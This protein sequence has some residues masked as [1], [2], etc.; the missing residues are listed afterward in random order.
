MYELNQR[1]NFEEILTLMINLKYLL[2]FEIKNKIKENESAF[3]LK[4]SPPNSNLQDFILKVLRDNLNFFSGIFFSKD[5][6]ISDIQIDSVNDEKLFLD[7]IGSNNKTNLPIPFDH[8]TLEIDEK[9][10][11]SIHFKIKNEVFYV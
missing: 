5:Y 4:E 3:I 11:K 8:T 7:Y 1:K 6:I 2:M 10:K 9:F